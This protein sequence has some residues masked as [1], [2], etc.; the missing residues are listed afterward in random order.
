MKKIIT[1]SMLI[2][3]SGPVLAEPSSLVAFDRETRALIRSG[4]A[5]NGPKLVKKV[6]CKKC[7]SE[8]GISD[9]TDNPT[10]AG[11]SATY[12]FK[13]LMDY[14][15]GSRSERSMKKAAKKLSLQDIADL[16]AYYSE[17]T[18]DVAAF[19]TDSVPVLVHK[20]DP[21]RMVRACNSCHGQNGEGGMYDMPSLVGQRKG[22]FITT[23]GEFK[24]D[25]RSNDIY[26]RM[27]DI[28][29][30]LTDEEIEQLANYY[31]AIDPDD[32]DD[33]DDD[34]EDKDEG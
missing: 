34:E 10:I 27:R 19:V 1:L 13:Q 31:S 9:D 15:N 12:I 8:N 17:Q 4:N 32:G 16:A 25:D 7:H 2:C 33:E 5:D 18:P 23:I 26:W 3:L 21:K 30:E 29:K 22:Y 14:K 28:A 20:G 6:K 11:M 24:E